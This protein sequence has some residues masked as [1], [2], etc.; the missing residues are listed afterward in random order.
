[1][2]IFGYGRVGTNQQTT[3]NQKLEL[4]NAGFKVDYCFTDTGISGK[5]SASLRPQFSLLLSQIRDG[6][7]L[8]ISKLD[9]LGRDALDVLQMVRNLAPLGPQSSNR[10]SCGFFCLLILAFFDSNWDEAYTEI[11]DT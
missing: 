2:A 1:M 10:R 4:E 5:T 8:V 6:E 7:T 3:D 11:S 9:R